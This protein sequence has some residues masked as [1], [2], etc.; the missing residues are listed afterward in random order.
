MEQTPNWWGKK[1]RIQQSFNERDDQFDP[2][3]SPKKLPDLMRQE[4]VL[5]LDDVE[6]AAASD[7]V[8]FVV[9]ALTL[10][11][12]RKPCFLDFICRS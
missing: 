4:E 11:K 8:D 3:F 12:E 10:L 1:S 5:V 6:V 2:I 7:D 9:D